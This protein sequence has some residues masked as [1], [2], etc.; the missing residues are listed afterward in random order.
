MPLSALLTHLTHRRYA[1]RGA[2]CGALFAL[3]IYLALSM[4]LAG[5]LPT[6]PFAGWAQLRLG[7]VGPMRYAPALL[8]VGAKLLLLIPFSLLTSLLFPEHRS[9][10]RQLLMGLGLAVLILALR[11]VQEGRIAPWICCSIR[12]GSALGADFT[13]CCTAL[14]RI[15]ARKRRSAARSACCFSL[16][17]ERIV[18]AA[19]SGN[20]PFTRRQR[21]NP[22]NPTE[23]HAEPLLT[24]D[25]YLRIPIYEQIVEQVEMHVALGDLAP[26]DQLPSVRALS[27]ELSVNPQHAAKGL[28]RA[29]AR[30]LCYTVPG[31][32][33]FTPNA[34]GKLRSCRQTLLM[35]IAEESI[36]LAQA[37]IPLDDILTMVKKRLQ[38][39]GPRRFPMIQVNGLTK[40]FGDFTAL[41]ALDCTIPAGCIYGLVGSNG[42]GNRRCCA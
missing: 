31:S 7:P 22:M 41:S 28:Y 30:G 27:V 15:F 13:V 24:V 3:G 11:S 14:R 33:R 19:G 20:D 40:K 34:A 1:C 12:Q 6:P 8:R 25:K 38:Q 39:G 26:E 35:N 16:L 21:R 5:I 29:G 37:G 18:S 10:A 36:Q 4:A 9:L 23:P 17:A 32:G 42:A 2:A